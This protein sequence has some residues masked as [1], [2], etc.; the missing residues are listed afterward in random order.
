[1]Q[2]VD[3]QP[4]AIRDD[5]L[6]DRPAD[7]PIQRVG[8]VDSR[9]PQNVEDACNEH[10]VASDHEGFVLRVFV[11]SARREDL[12]LEEVEGGIAVHLN[13]RRCVLTLPDTNYGHAT[14]WAYEQGVLSVNLSG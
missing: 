5:D 14:A 7:G 12:R 4:F 9:D 2:D 6:D 1:L 13:G 11:P 3:G 10:T 8:R